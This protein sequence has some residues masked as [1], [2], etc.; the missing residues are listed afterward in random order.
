MLRLQCM[1]R[2]SFG[3]HKEP[4]ETFNCVQWFCACTRHCHLRHGVLRD[5]EQS[6]GLSQQSSI[7]SFNVLN[8]LLGTMY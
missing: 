4:M 1:Q 7:I 3:Q 6:I 5:Q 8:L 2:R